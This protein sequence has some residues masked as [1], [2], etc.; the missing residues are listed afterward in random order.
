MVINLID[1]KMMNILYSNMYRSVKN[2]KEL[3]KSIKNPEGTDLYRA[4][5]NDKWLDI[6]YSKLPA[7]TKNTP[8]NQV[9]EI[10]QQQHFIS[11]P[12]GCHMSTCQES[13]F[14][15]TTTSGN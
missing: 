4:K 1:V 15:L 2:F 12:E 5:K 7:K 14:Q 6:T 9:Q 8:T 10:L 11:N 13:V 3:C